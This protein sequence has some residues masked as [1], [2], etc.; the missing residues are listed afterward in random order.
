MTTYHMHMC[1]FTMIYTCI[2]ETS[3]YREAMHVCREPAYTV[4]GC[5]CSMYDGACLHCRA[6]TGYAT[7]LYTINFFLLSVSSLEKNK[8][9]NKL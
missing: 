4:G 8:Q 5:I 2:D 6:A 9:T 7:T 1:T 3:L